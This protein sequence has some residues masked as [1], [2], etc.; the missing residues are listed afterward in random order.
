M[1][2]GPSWDDRKWRERIMYRERE[3]EGERERERDRWRA[4]AIQVF[5][6][7]LSVRHRAAQPEVP[8]T[9]LARPTL[10]TVMARL[11][12]SRD[13]A[14]RSEGHPNRFGDSRGPPRPTTSR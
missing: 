10:W 7:L 5:G 11:E 6:A 13:S 2:V 8:P 12:T 9:L 3:R 14:G 4:G 1:Q